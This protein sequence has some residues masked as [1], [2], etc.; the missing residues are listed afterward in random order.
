MALPAS[1]NM[2]LRDI[3]LEVEGSSSGTYALS[4]AVANSNPAVDP[5]SDNLPPAAMSDFY[6]HTQVQTY[7]RLYISN[8]D[9]DWGASVSYVCSVDSNGTVTYPTGSSLELNPATANQTV[10]LKNG[11]SDF[12][13][14]NQVDIVCKRRTKN[15]SNSWTTYQTLTNYASTAI[16]CT[17]SSYDYLFEV[18][19]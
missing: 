19:K 7:G 13:P 17:F 10:T 8:N 18:T 5:N 12:V 1:G 11:L 2:S 9:V 3:Q 14:Q 15:T 16:T 4:T 6:S